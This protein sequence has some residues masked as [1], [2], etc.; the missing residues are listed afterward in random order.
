MD[1]SYTL[2]ENGLGFYE[3][4]PKP[5]AHYLRHYY[6]NKYYGTDKV[7]NQYN[8]NYTEDELIHKQIESF[9]ALQY[10][11]GEVGRLI[12]IGFGE[13]FFLD[14]FHSLGWQISG[15]DFTCDGLFKYHPH[16]KDKV[17]VGDVFE[18]IEALIVENKK[19][20]LVICNNVLEHVIDP[21]VLLNHIRKLLAP[22]G[23][24]RIVVP[25]DGSWL[26]QEIVN[27]DL[28]ANDYW[29]CPPDHLNYFT[30]TSLSKTLRSSEFDI[31]D[32]LGSFPIDFFL[33]NPDTNYQQTPGLGRNCH[34]ARVAFEV[35]LFR[36]SIQN[37]IEFRRGCAKAGIGRDLVVYCRAVTGE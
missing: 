6:N 24:A 10:L 18:S 8:H 36:Q 4:F 11:P 33:L 1:Y 25:N 32:I 2:I 29:V 14:H 13:G 20:D 17:L 5:S 28:A 15:V 3:V 7:N 23:M 34:F 22:G 26:Q 16:L 21:L 27:R 37:L 19:Y 12:E 30:V 31:V 9:E 35:A